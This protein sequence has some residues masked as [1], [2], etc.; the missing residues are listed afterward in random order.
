MRL[1][2]ADHDTSPRCRERDGALARGGVF[3]TDRF[4]LPQALV[5]LHFPPFVHCH[6][7]A[8]LQ[9]VDLPDATEHL[10]ATLR[11][12]PS[13]A[14][15]L[16]CLAT[17]ELT[18]NR[19][20]SA[21]QYA[22][23]LALA[24]PQSAAGQRLLASIALATGEVATAIKHA[25]VALVLEPERAEAHYVLG[26]ALARSGDYQSAAAELR[27]AVKLDSS[28]HEAE[29]VLREVESKLGDASLRGRAAPEQP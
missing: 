26:L 11:W 9:N 2:L 24:Q 28:L 14:H 17:I 27:R 18:Q 1:S 7:A 25:R 8:A 16:W 10:V 12:E 20:E 5:R 21:M 22:R 19:F 29:Q 4:R 15:S 3:A 6:A 13:H 23:T